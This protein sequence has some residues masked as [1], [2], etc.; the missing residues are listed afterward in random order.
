MLR[1]YFKITRRNLLKD[2]GYS[3]LNIAGLYIGFV[4]MVL[5]VLYLSHELSFDKHLQRAEDTYRLLGVSNTTGGKG[6]ESAAPWGPALKDQFPEIEDY[7]RIIG[8]G[9]SVFQV[10]NNRFYEN[11][12]IIADASILKLF[13]VDLLQGDKASA[14]LEPNQVVIKERLAKKYFGDD[15]PIGKVIRIDNE[16][17]YTVTGVLAD[18]QKPSHLTFDFIASFD[19]HDSWF[20][21]D[22]FIRNYQTFFL[23]NSDAEAS[24]VESKLTA[25][26]KERFETPETPFDNHV[27]LQQ[28]SEIHLYDDTADQ[29][30]QIGKVRLVGV[31]G[32]FI[33]IIALVNYVNLVTARSAKRFKE[34][35]V[36]K[37]IGARRRQLQAQFLIENIIVCFSVFVITMASFNLFMPGF[38]S[39]MNSDLSFSLFGDVQLVGI[40]FLVT[41]LVSLASGFY[42]AFILSSLN[43][44]NLIK[45]NAV[46]LGGKNY[47]RK[48]LTT[49]QFIIS[50]ALIIGTS[51]V[52]KQLQYMLNKDVGF[53][54]EQ[55]VVVPLGSSEVWRN[56]NVFA[57]QIRNFSEV[58]E[59][60]LTA[61]QIG[62]GDWGMPFQYE[63]GERPLNVRF[64]S[65]DAAYG[66]TLGLKLVEGRFFKEELKTDVES[67]FIVNEAF[68]QAVGWGSGIGKRIEMPTR[69]SENPWLP[70]KIVGVV[71]D[72]NFRSLHTQISPMVIANKV[73]WTST[74][75]IKLN[76][77]STDKVLT[78]LAEAWKATE[79]NIPFGY[80][81][82]DEKLAEQYVAETRLSK[83][84]TTF[85]AIAIVLACIGL[86]SLATYTAEQ[87]M[88]EVS[89]RKVMG[90]SLNQIWLLFSRQFMVIII[91]SITIAIPISL[92]YL[93][94]WLSEFA[95]RIEI[96][97]NIQ[98]PVLASLATVFVAML[99]I[100]IQSIRLA[101]SNPVKFLRSE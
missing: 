71:K 94:G 86:F 67:S 22:W 19:S 32:G 20:K 39:L 65:I 61:N 37:S 25:F 54:K 11:G 87:K 85:G 76:P 30:P 82:L 95:Y 68:L 15:N 97:Q 31:I 14:L 73:D 63:G 47:L 6:N 35:G 16:K 3:L 77:G 52:Y 55:V 49:L 45:N 34:V 58:K 5:T 53:D 18:K 60:A 40:M 83:M 42:P 96:W 28:V 8:H 36:R 51:L 4:C 2:R 29:T 38:N 27:E 91:V 100:A 56:K 48:S 84:A 69:D 92:Y 24:D 26:F 13:S 64:M 74:L 17:L 1:N 9:A 70:G 98:I 66:E 7:T 81:F 75:F 50:V 57:E 10:D 41:L 46:G 89:I 72:F 99:T 44:V 62:G 59:V 12:G 88:K 80:Y 21:T 79:P 33:L 93:D 43:P 78:D 101:K 23:L 90:A